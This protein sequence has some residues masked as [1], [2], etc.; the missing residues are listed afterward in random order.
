MH[1][2]TMD[3]VS[4][5]IKSAVLELSFWVGEDVWQAIVS[6]C[7]WFANEMRTKTKKTH[8][9]LITPLFLLPQH[10]VC[11]DVRGQL[12]ESEAVAVNLSLFLVSKWWKT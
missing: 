4:Q 7:D 9:L 1:A 6:K 10:F 2:Q 11:R 12:W 3:Q 8:Q 5:S